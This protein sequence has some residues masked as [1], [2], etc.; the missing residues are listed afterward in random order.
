MRT[1]VEFPDELLLRAKSTAALAG[2]SLKEFLIE[3]VE[4]RLQAKKAKPRLELPSIG[5]P[6]GR[7]MKAPTREQIDEAMFG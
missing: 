6:K 3:A 5:D 2:L 1:T 4:G 7:K